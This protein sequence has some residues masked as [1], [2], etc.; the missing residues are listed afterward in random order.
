MKKTLIV[1]EYYPS[2]QNIGSS[3]RTLNFA[4]Y[5]RSIGTVDIAYSALFADGKIGNQI[6]SKE[7]LLEK[8]SEI[9][10]QEL[11]VKWISIWKRP[12]EIS[13][14]EKN[15]EMLLLNLIKRNNYDYILVRY[16][17]NSWALFQTNKKY[18]KR[19]I[20]DFDD[21]ISGSI[22]SSKI[23]AEPKWNRKKRLILNRKFLKKYEIKCLSF[24]AALFCSHQDMSTLA[25]T[26][27][28]KRNTFVVPNAYSE[29]SFEDYDFG[30][31]YNR[32]NHLLF[33]GNLGYGPN[34][35]GLKWFLEFVFPDF[36]RKY[37]DAILNVVGR[38]PVP[39]VK[40]LVEN[41]AGV[42]LYADVPDIRL[43]YAQCKAVVVPLLSGGGT[44]IKILEAGLTQRPILSTRLGAEGLDFQ[45]NQN[46]LLFEESTD[47]LKQYEKLFDQNIYYGIVWKAKRIVKENYSS[48][49]FSKSMNTVINYLE[50]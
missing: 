32:P 16:V 36:R 47:F 29:K 50:S 20:I 6:F 11:F 28:I 42:N 41:N 27:C 43:H 13:L 21:V 33:V 18:R 30:S 25:F 7:Y 45:N 3:I 26:R 39:E 15:S 12:L 49:Q 23:E 48:V 10:L 34:V 46:I 8:K 4:R 19:V 37:S 9:N 17:F 44:R 5:F 22:S 31:G 1:C 35:Q 38:F 40:K 24:G 2:P 14:L